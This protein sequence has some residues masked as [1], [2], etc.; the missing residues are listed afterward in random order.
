MQERLAW[1]A[2]GG[3]AAA[4]L[5]LLAWRR[6]AA[7]AAAAAD[8]AAPFSLPERRAAAGARSAFVLA[9]NLR[10]A[11][12][13]QRSHFLSIWAPL[14]AHVRGGEPG[15]LAF[16]LLEADS[17]PLHVLVYE[18]YTSRE[19]YEGP[20]RSSAAFH[21]FKA[22]MADLPF[23]VDVVGQSFVESNTLSGH[24]N[25]LVALLAVAGTA[26]EIARVAAVGAPLMPTVAATTAGAERRRA[27]AAADA[28]RQLAAAPDLAAVARHA[29]VVEDHG[30]SSPA[31]ALL[32]QPAAARVLQLLAAGGALGQ[33]PSA[34]HLAAVLMQGVLQQRPSNS[35]AEAWAQQVEADLLPHLA[36]AA[37][38]LATELEAGL[39]ARPRVALHPG[40]AIGVW[41]LIGAAPAFMAAV[42]EMHPQV[43]CAL[44]RA[45][46]GLARLSRAAALAAPA[47]ARRLSLI[48]L[49]NVLAFYSLSNEAGR[50]ELL[51]AVQDEHVQWFVL[52]EL[53]ATAAGLAALQPAGRGTPAHAALL[54]ALGMD[55]GAGQHSAEVQNSDSEHRRLLSRARE[56]CE[57]AAV[58][59]D[60]VQ[61]PG[62]GNPLTAQLLAWVAAAVPALLECCQRGE[63]AS[64]LCNPFQALAACLR[65]L[66]KSPGPGAGAA[67]AFAAA[68]AE[69]AG[70]L[71]TVLRALSSSD[72]PREARASDRQRLCDE[73]ADVLKWVIAYGRRL[74]PVGPQP[75]HSGSGG[76]SGGSY[77]DRA[78]WLVLAARGL[79]LAARLLSEPVLPAAG[80]DSPADEDVHATMLWRPLLESVAWLEPA[81]SS[82]AG[83]AAGGGA[84]GASS[85]AGSACLGARLLPPAVLQPLLEQLA[86]ARQALEAAQPA[87]ERASAAAAGSV[88]AELRALRAAMRPEL[89][90][91]LAALGEAV[92]GALP[93]RSACSN[94][95]CA[96]LAGLSEVALAEAAVMAAAAEVHV[97]GERG[98]A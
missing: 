56:A 2:A 66:I 50:A 76:D 47:A 42:L 10:F 54:A 27:A 58:V 41:G 77:D 89:A 28:L 29:A 57:A 44:V 81:L 59:L 64:E 14:A 68:H 63:G 49:L 24:G 70:L 75:G 43:L 67:A 4:G 6:V 62:T 39:A 15:T 37:E 88:E 18:R 98:G 3:A 52:Y 5:V 74:L 55:L 12:A 95:A 21:Q 38:A 79:A 51:R 93:L 11:N 20:H 30:T 71:A 45:L 33:Q 32:L 72:P 31:L 53:A 13:A 87:L 7:A 26:D 34:V 73:C 92:C 22:A 85:S 78:P 82:L 80:G 35:D 25:S 36:S 97:A 65:V 40:A 48:T 94:P 17:D 1:A 8:A 61:P 86:A 90:A 69:L 16:E 46:P 19:A 9:V 23:K 91:Q 84:Q 83:A 60:G 96:N